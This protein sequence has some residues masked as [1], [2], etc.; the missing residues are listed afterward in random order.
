MLIEWKYCLNRVFYVFDH[1]KDVTFNFDYRFL[2][3][4]EG[5]GEASHRETL[6][7][8]SLVGANRVGK[9]CY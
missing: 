7:R 5:R 6:K 2:C 1:R 3:Y 8:M 9:Y 4:V